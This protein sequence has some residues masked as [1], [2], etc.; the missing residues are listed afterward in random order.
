MKTKIFLTGLISIL[1]CG[2]C[3]ALPEVEFVYF[4]LSTNEIWIER[5]IGLPAEASP[6]RMAPAKGEDRPSEKSMTFFE[7]VRVADKLKIVWKDNGRQGWPGGGKAGELSRPGVVHEAEFKRDDFK[8]PAKMKSG[9][10]R[11]TFLGNDKWRIT[12]L[13]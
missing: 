11:F 12:Y 8:I 9:K 13:K 7:T 6:G 1:F 4:N 2:S 3:L 10:V 5:V